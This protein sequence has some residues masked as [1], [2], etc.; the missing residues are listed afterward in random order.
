MIR[1]ALAVVKADVMAA[2]SGTQTVMTYPKSLGGY[3][4][5]L[6]EKLNEV[7]G[8][9]GAIK[10]ELNRGQQRINQSD[11]SFL[12]LFMILW[13]GTGMKKIKFHKFIRA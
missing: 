5:D 2:S 9:F 3:V 11:V 12:Y 6:L 1:A 10:E 13:Q 8:I 4:I 7:K